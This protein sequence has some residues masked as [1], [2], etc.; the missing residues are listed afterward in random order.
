MAKTVIIRTRR[1]RR[2]LEA[3]SV[4]LTALEHIAMLLIRRAGH[5]CS[6]SIAPIFGLRFCS[7]LELARLPHF[8]QRPGKT[9]VAPNGKRFRRRR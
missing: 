1:A 6:F 8:F 3:S 2:C 7:D 5:G 4:A 9:Y